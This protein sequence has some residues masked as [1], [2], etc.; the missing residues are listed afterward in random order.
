M[1][2]LILTGLL[3]TATT[4]MAQVKCTNTASTTTKSS[5]ANINI[6]GQDELDQAASYAKGD[7]DSFNGVS[8]DGIA[9]SDLITKDGAVSTVTTSKAESYVAPST[10]TFSS[11]SVTLSDG[12]IAQLDTS[13]KL[14][15]SVDSTATMTELAPAT[16]TSITTRVAV[17]PI[18]TTTY[19]AVAPRL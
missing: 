18:S 3:L 5:C 4:A 8:L 15:E 1:R 19:T 16:E 13:G 12:S 9:T 14:I 10:T 11:T 2:T 6:L 17:E 7:L